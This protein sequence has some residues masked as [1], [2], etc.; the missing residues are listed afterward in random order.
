MLKYPVF[1]CFPNEEILYGVG[2]PYGF[3]ATA[4]EALRIVAPLRRNLYYTP[5]EVVSVVLTEVETPNYFID[6]P[7]WSPTFVQDAI[8]EFSADVIVVT[9]NEQGQIM[10]VTLTA[11]WI[12]EEHD[13]QGIRYRYDDPAPTE[14]DDDAEEPL[15][16]TSEEAFWLMFGVE[17]AGNRG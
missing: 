1:A 4:E 7:P 13:L 10:K 14:A 2:S 17:P 9:T 11:W 5:R 3:A 6:A 12:A 16:Q 15:A 8:E